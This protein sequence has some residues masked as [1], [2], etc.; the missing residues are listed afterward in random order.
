MKERRWLVATVL[1]AMLIRL[2]LLLTPGYDV[3]G[4]KAWARGVWDVG[5]GG[6][7]AQPFPDPGGPYH[8]SPLFL[9]IL[10]AVGF[11]YTALRPGGP[12]DDQLLATLIK[13]PG[14][15]VE[16]GLGLL[17]WRF[18]RIRLGPR[19]A[20]GALAAYLLNPA[21]IWN[22]AYWGSIDILHALPTTA[23]LIAAEIGAAGAAGALAALALGSKLTAL[24][25]VLAL[26]PPLLRTPRR[27]A[28]A[29]AG[30]LITLLILL[31]PF[32]ARGQIGAVVRMIF[33]N[34]GLYPSASA[35]AHNLWWLVTGGQGAR[36]D[37]T[38]IAPGLDYRR[39]GFLL[40]ALLALPTLALLWRRGTDLVLPFAASGFLSFAFCMVTTEVHENWFYPLFAPLLVAAALDR[41]YRPLY[42][43]LSLTF[44]ANLA[45]HDPPLFTLLG[46]GILAP[47]RPLRLL[48]TAA[49]CAALIWWAWL[50]FHR[51]SVPPQY[52]E[53]PPR[54]RKG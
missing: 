30:G 15:V 28:L 9:Y 45:L 13:L 4:Y 29:I 26:A 23:A 7:Y 24:P 14:S 25:G 44:L 47:A 31:I 6:A 38:L 42:A 53:N 21:L 27:A 34:V 5:V 49:Q 8:Y 46:D 39:A 51:P 33:G 41:R 52:K 50:L 35:N 3:R 40:F 32:I 11:V 10:R 12:W 54:V 19:A 1:L 18:V 2:P 43:A 37:T 48:N 22:T 17:L 16:L 20:L 36:L